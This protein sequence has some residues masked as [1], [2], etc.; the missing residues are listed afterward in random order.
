MFMV[1]NTKPIIADNNANKIRKGFI[2]MIQLNVPNT[3]DKIPDN[4]YK[5]ML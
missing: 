3:M 5:F 1:E 4:L 2:K